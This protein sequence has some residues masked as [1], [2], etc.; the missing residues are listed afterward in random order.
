[1]GFRST[2]SVLHPGDASDSVESQ[3]SGDGRLTLVGAIETHTCY[4]ADRG[5]SHIPTTIAIVGVEELVTSSVIFLLL[6]SFDRGRKD[7]VTD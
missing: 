3:P 2:W 4:V 1:V 6:M 5:Y 7:S